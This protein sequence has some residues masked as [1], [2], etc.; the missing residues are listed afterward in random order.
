MLVF[1]FL[2]LCLF[3]PKFPM[4]VLHHGNHVCVWH[5]NL[6][7]WDHAE[8]FLLLFQHT[9]L[10]FQD[11][12]HVGFATVPKVYQIQSLFS[13]RMNFFKSSRFLAEKEN[14]DWKLVWLH[15]FCLRTV[16]SAV[17]QENT[18]RVHPDGALSQVFV[19]V[20]RCVNLCLCTQVC[21]GR[22]RDVKRCTLPVPSRYF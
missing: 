21:S 19:S 12:L 2:S 22:I 4:R 3:I 18:C 20:S 13:Q 7:Q 15:L 10:F 5:G 1:S 8:T 17:S 9:I 16:K 6:F 14:S 11:I